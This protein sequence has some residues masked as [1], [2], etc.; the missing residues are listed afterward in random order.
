MGKAPPRSRKE[1]SGVEWLEEIYALHGGW[2]YTLRLWSEYMLPMHEIVS[3]YS[4]ENQLF[5][6]GLIAL[7]A[8]GLE[9]LGQ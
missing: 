2:K 1:R 3:D 8:D 6:G 5:R 4:Y 9:T 7:G